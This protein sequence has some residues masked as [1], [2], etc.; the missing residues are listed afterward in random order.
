M[1]APRFSAISV[2]LGPDAVGHLALAR[3]AKGN[4]INREMW[5]EL[6][7]GLEHLVARGA[8]AVRRLPRVAG[9]QGRRRW[10][11]LKTGEMLGNLHKG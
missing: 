4:A 8:R 5:N 6:G 1:A 11:P 9:E 10:L 7:L 3:P 2:S